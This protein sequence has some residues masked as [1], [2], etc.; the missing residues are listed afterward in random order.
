MKTSTNALRLLVLLLV[1]CAAQVANATSYT[2]NVASPGAN[3]WNVN[4]NWSP[5][6]GNPGSSDTAIFGVTGTA[7]AQTTINNIVSV[8]TPITALNYTNTSQWHVTQ[9]PLNSTLT[10]SGATTVGGF[11]NSAV[12]SA[13]MT[14][15][16][17]FSA[18][19]NL[20]IGNSGSSSGDSGTILDLSALTNFVCNA[21]S[22]TIAMGLGNRS[23][24]NFKLANTNVITVGTWN[25]NATTTSSSASGTLTLG[26]ATNIINV[27]TF[28]ISAQ[29]GSCTVQFPG[30]G[31]V[32]RLRGTGG[33]DSDR[34][35][36]TIANRNP[37][38]SVSAGGN[39]GTLNLT[40][41]PWI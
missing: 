40:A 22:G 6:T 36:M 3:N 16:G 19:G 32:L 21:S 37:S 5:S 2:W 31:S 35:T 11:T 39:T 27:G 23:G 25:A 18:N 17:T 29:R 26:A 10:V 28:N 8:N 30:S 38:G 33:T 15:A 7:S 14:G 13:A 24:A 4:A 34:C 12:T 20:I 41:I 1:A 9:I